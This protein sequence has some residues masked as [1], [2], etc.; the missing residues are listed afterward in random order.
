[1]QSASSAFTDTLRFGSYLAVARMTVLSNGVSTQIQVPISEMTVTVDRNSETRR[2]GSLTVE[3]VPTDPP[4]ELMPTSPSSL[5]APFGNEIFAEFSV[6]TDP[7]NIDNAEW[8]PLGIFAIATTT[9]DD[10]TIDVVVTLDLYDRSWVIAQRKLLAPY[11]VPAAGGGFAQEIEALLNQVWGQS[12]NMPPLQYNIAPTD[13]VVPSGTY[14]Q[15]EDPWQAALDMAASAGY[16]LF[17][18]VHGVVTGYPI[19]NPTTQPIVWAFNQNSVSVQGTLNPPSSYDYTVGQSPFATPIGISVTMT[20]DGIYNDFYV[21]ATGPQNAPGGSSG[22]TAPAQVNA[23]DT[24]P[25]SP[26][27]IGGGMGNVPNFVMDSLITTAAQAQAEANY[28]LA[29]A[30]A[31]SWLVQVSTPPNPLFDIDDVIALFNSR[32]GL[33]GTKVVLDT[34]TFSVRYDAATTLSG[35]VVA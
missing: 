34:I 14:N 26:T 2:Q 9:I 13:Y 35:R 30:L 7:A 23:A 19:P 5:L 4:T 27:Y 11:N 1:M 17:F 20:R 21:S 3:V 33:N 6:V 28:D 32:M 31:K 18:D 29:Q 25:G 22:S 8:I 16:E 10:S 24:N 15:G 12:G